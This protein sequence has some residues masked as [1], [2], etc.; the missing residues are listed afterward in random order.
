MTI[1]VHLP[2]HAHE[3]CH[4]ILAVTAQVLALFGP[5]KAGCFSDVYDI[6]IIYRNHMFIYSIW[7]M[8][9]LS[10][11]FWCLWCLHMV[12]IVTESA[13]E[14]HQSHVLDMDDTCRVTQ[15]LETKTQR[16]VRFL[17]RFSFLRSTTCMSNRSYNGFQPFSFWERLETSL[18]WL[19]S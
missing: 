1:L 8:I 16:L 13:V 15:N 9:F 14:W 3:C 6:Y 2:R 5:W 17:R 19:V 12:P 18:Y 10:Q 4:M 11:W 7:F